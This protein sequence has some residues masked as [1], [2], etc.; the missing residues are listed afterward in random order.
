ME[1]KIKLFII[2]LSLI[3][4]IPLCYGGTLDSVASYTGSYNGASCSEKIAQEFEVS[5]EGQLESTKIYGNCHLGGGTF[6]WRLRDASGLTGTNVDSLPVIASGTANF[7]EGGT[8]SNPLEIQIFS[9]QSIEVLNGDRLLL[10][11][12]QRTGLFQWFSGYGSRPGERFYYNN[13]AWHYASVSGRESGR[14]IYLVPVP[15]ADL[16]VDSLSIEPS[17]IV[18]PDSATINWTIKNIGTAEA[19]PV[20]YWFKVRHSFDPF[21]DETDEYVAGRPII[22]NL[23]PGEKYSSTFNFNSG[24]YV[25]GSYFFIAKVDTTDIVD[26][27]SENNNYSTDWVTLVIELPNGHKVQGYVK[28]STGVPFSGVTVTLTGNGENLTDYTQ[29]DGYYHFDGLA[30]GVYEVNASKS[31]WQFTNSPQTATV[32]GDDSWLD[33]MLGNPTPDEVLSKPG[34]PTG[35][36]EPIA[37]LPYTYSTAGAISNLGHTVEY[38]FNWGDGTTSGW[39]TSTSASHS[40]DSNDQRTITVTARC[41]TH[42]DIINISDGLIVTPFISDDTGDGV[43]WSAHAIRAD[44]LHDVGYT[45]SGVRVGSVEAAEAYAEHEVFAVGRLTNLPHPLVPAGD[46]KHATEVAG[47]TGGNSTSYIGVAPATTLTVADL[48]PFA[49]LSLAS[50]IEQLAETEDVINVEIATGALTNPSDGSD[51]AERSADWA[52]RYKAVTIVVPGGNHSMTIEVPAGGYNSITVG[53]TDDFREQGQDSPARPQG[54][55]KY[56]YGNYGP[57]EDGRCKPD[58]VAPAV[59][60][61]VPVE[62]GGYGVASGTSFAAPHVAGAA[63]LLIQQGRDQ[64]WLTEPKVI[65]ALL[66][67]GAIKPFVWKRSAVILNAGSQTWLETTQPLDFELGAGLVNVEGASEI[68]S[69][70]RRSEGLPSNQT[71]Q[72]GWDKDH[73]NLANTPTTYILGCKQIAPDA[74]ITA[75]LVW[76]RNILENRTAEDHDILSMV[77]SRLE[78][79]QWSSVAS[80]ISMVDNIQHIYYR[81]PFGTQPSNYRLDVHYGSDNDSIPGCNYAIAWNVKTLG[82]RT[83]QNGFFSAGNLSDWAISGDGSV[84]VETKTQC[85]G[86]PYAAKLILEDAGSYVETAEVIGPLNFTDGELEFSYVSQVYGLLKV[87]V[88]DSEVSSFPTIDEVTYGWVP[89]HF[90]VLGE[91]PKIAF[92]L[93]SSDGISLSDVLID[94]IQISPIGGTVVVAGDIDKNLN[95]DFTD[96]SFLAAQWTQ[97]PGFPSADIAPD[98]GDCIVNILDLCEFAEHWLENIAP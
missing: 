16:I 53:G 87:Y 75:T 84:T 62:N 58:I 20:N 6:V 98:D 55:K 9:G 42:N 25:A 71:S 48:G 37:N 59:S 5:I 91:T 66:M 90:D 15:K 38:R 40:W 77:L 4:Q 52:V 36:I 60:I 12:E 80:S 86:D 35:Q 13:G 50:G 94:N 49:S 46:R 73:I 11:I 69:S 83:V 93:I 67:T 30:D 45:G 17:T 10:E 95:I 33:D 24:D 31:G 74:V 65:K 34:T 18:Q 22:V 1:R 23:A 81:V 70:G 96:F 21:Y 32:N 2:V 61:D 92:R 26:E 3:I 8:Y 82:Y 47:I 29:A 41:Q 39:S 78:N 79:S 68:Y 63:A 76:N 97:G 54:A 14:A 27:L 28:Y 57:T 85:D 19:I 56:Y 64:G 7:P 44:K 51:S 43:L 88:N 72:Q 89:L